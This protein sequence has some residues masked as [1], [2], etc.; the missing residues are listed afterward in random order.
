MTVSRSGRSDD[1]SSEGIRL[2]NDLVEIGCWPVGPVE[3]RTRSP[4]YS[5]ASNSRDRAVRP[6]RRQRAPSTISAARYAAKGSRGTRNNFSMDD[7][8]RT[9]QLPGEAM[10]GWA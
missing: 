6:E 1:S 9:A 8:N 7:K 4:Q 5:V 3:M 2:M 10:I